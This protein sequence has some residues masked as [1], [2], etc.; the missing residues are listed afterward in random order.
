MTTQPPAP[1]DGFEGHTP[2]PWIVENVG[3]GYGQ[4]AIMPW[5][6]RERDALL[7]NGVSIDAL[8]E[9][10]ANRA[11]IARAPDLLAENARLRLALKRIDDWASDDGDAFVC[12]IARAALNPPGGQG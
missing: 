3:G 2:G 4:F 9:R 11:L 12:E 8:R 1:Q 5:G 7:A 6:A 10:N